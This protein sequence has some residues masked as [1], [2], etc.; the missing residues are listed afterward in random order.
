[1]KS[2]NTK[3]KKKTMTADQLAELNA[4]ENQ[5]EDYREDVANQKPN[6]RE[7]ESDTREAQANLKKEKNGLAKAEKD[8]ATVK[9]RLAKLKTKYKGWAKP[10]P[11][12]TGINAAAESVESSAS[13]VMED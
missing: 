9:K 2:K 10:K 12:D 4:T 13:Q 3:A 5:V 6:V 11:A 1:M 7:A 8:L